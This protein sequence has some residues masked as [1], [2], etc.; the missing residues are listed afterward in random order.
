VPNTSNV[1]PEC[2]SAT[3]TTIV[4]GAEGERDASAITSPSHSELL[5]GKII[6]DG[7][8]KLLS[9]LWTKD[10]KVAREHIVGELEHL[11][12]TDLEFCAEN[13]VERRVWQAVFYRPAEALRTALKTNASPTEREDIR[14]NLLSLLDEGSDVYTRMLDALDKTY[15][16]RLQ[17][18]LEEE[19]RPARNNVALA[20]ARKFLLRMGDLARYSKKWRKSVSFCQDLHQFQ[21]SLRVT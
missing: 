15:S 8:G 7:G 18:T 4:H 19:T 13:G 10:V 9:R 16:L 14:T 2:N 11:L 5:L 17:E 12:E 1:T 3:D 21:I 6:A 20:S